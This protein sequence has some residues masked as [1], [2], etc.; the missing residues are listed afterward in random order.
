[1]D[2]F[3][4]SVEELEKEGLI[5]ECNCGDDFCSSEGY[6]WVCSLA[7]DNKCRWFPSPVRCNNK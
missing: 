7:R 4:A 2:L 3:P 1:M 5:D 6:L